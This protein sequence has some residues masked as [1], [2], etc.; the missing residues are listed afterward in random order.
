MNSNALCLS[1]GIILG[2][3]INLVFR[4]FAFRQR[5]IMGYERGPG[6][7][8][9]RLHRYGCGAQ[10]QDS[11]SQLAKRLHGSRGR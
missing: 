11:G 2:M 5:R 7:A 3:N 4:I 10:A 8:G 6:V 9:T 1:L